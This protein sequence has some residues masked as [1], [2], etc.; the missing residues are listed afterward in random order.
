MNFTAHRA[1]EFGGKTVTFVKSPPMCAAGGK[2][3]LTLAVHML[4]YLHSKFQQII[5][6]IEETEGM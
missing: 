4:M 5:F 6:Q 3:I 1:S 2:V